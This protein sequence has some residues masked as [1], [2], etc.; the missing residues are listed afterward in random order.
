[1]S[2]EITEITLETIKAMGQIGEIYLKAQQRIAELRLE[3]YKALL[4]L[5]MTIV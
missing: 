5:L 4:E 3:F 1:M 2:K